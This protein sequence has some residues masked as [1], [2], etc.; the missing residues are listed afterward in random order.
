MAEPMSSNFLLGSGLKVDETP[1]G[2]SGLHWAAYT[3]RV[4][5]VKL[6]LERK[7]PLELRDGRH[8]GTPLGW[9]FH[10]WVDSPP[11][12][13]DYYEVVVLLV[14][15]GATVNSALPADPRRR[16]LLIEKMRAD[17]RMA[18]ALKGEMPAQ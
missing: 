8:R 7:A 6:L 14:A 12:P 5:I 13:G 10:A 16:G 1:H 3:A 2:I 18:A 15:A 9:A 4:D 17:T 11:E